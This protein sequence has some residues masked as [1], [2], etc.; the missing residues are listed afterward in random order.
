M[1]R[2]KRKAKTMTT[3]QSMIYAKD[4]CENAG[5]DCYCGSMPSDYV[6]TMN[7]IIEKIRI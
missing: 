2:L 4:I 5:A 3:I 6:A 7:R 1:K